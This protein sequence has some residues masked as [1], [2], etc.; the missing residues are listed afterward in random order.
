MITKYIGKDA[1]FYD[2]THE[3]LIA[4]E[5]KPCKICKKL[6]HSDC[7]KLNGNIVTACSYEQAQEIVMSKIEL[8]LER[9]ENGD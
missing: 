1:I 8:F 4:S 2:I 6:T 3:D 5:L 7:Y 9:I